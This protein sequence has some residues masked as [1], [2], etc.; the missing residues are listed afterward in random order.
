MI[1]MGLVVEII[2]II[3]TSDMITEDEFGSWL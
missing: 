1:G 2:N 3:G